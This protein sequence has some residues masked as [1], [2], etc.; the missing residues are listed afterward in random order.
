M[1]AEHE[2]KAKKNQK[3]RE[4]NPHVLETN[5]DGYGCAVAGLLVIYR[6]RFERLGSVNIS[7]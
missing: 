7:H 1:D 2:K 6:P 3:I 4:K 5:I